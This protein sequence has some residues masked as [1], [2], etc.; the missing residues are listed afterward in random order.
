V[1]RLGLQPEEVADAVAALREAAGRYGRRPDLGDLEITRHPPAPPSREMARRYA[2]VG[3]HRLVIEP[4]TSPG[5]A[6]DELIDGR[7][8]SCSVLVDAPQ[9]ARFRSVPDV[10]AAKARA[11]RG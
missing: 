10:A 8:R 6:M 11:G 4:P 7:R 1:V 9:P 2:E 3:V 5:S